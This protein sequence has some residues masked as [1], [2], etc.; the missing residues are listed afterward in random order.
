MRK[1]VLGVIDVKWNKRTSD[2]KLSMDALKAVYG[3]VCS[4]RP[5]ER[6]DM[7]LEPLQAMVQISLLAVCPVGTKLSI[8][9][10]LLQLQFP[11]WKQ[12][13]VRRYNADSKDDLVYLFNVIRRFKRFYAHTKSTDP[14]LFALL[15]CMGTA[16]LDRLVQTYS[17]AGAGSVNLV[18]TLRMYREM[19]AQDKTLEIEE[20]PNETS[21]ETVFQSVSEVYNR[22]HL[23]VIFNTLKLAGEDEANHLSYAQGLEVVLTPIN[24]V[25]REWINKNIAL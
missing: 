11:S 23:A 15:V 16:G 17:A 1:Y 2:I 22:S 12:G 18:Q 24:T 4:D 19:L 8:H 6:Y 25:I 3:A 5:K 13:V 7:L 20:S 10:N 21:V 9:N 14:E